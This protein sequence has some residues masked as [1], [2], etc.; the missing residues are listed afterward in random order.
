MSNRNRKG[1]QRMLFAEKQRARKLSPEQATA[2]VRA[3]GYVESSRGPFGV[4]WRKG[5]G[6]GPLVGI[7]AAHKPGLAAWMVECVRDLAEAEGR[8]PAELLDLLESMVLVT[9]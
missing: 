8:P 7:P 1:R 2:Y 5:E 6:R 9:S 4:V 3:A